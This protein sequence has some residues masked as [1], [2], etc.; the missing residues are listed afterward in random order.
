LSLK[1]INL[2]FTDLDSTVLDEN[3]NFK[4]EALDCIQKALR[5][6]FVIIF[7]SSKTLAEQQY[8]STKIGLPVIYIVENGSAI[9]I[10]EN[11]FD[12]ISH[13][14]GCRKFVLSRFSVSYVREV[15][16][17]I[18]SESQSIKF[19]GNSTLKEIMEYTGLSMKMAR[20]AKDREYTETIFKGFTSVIENKLIQYGLFPQKGSRFVTVGDKVD[21]GTA[22]TKLISLLKNEGYTIKRTIGVGDGPNDIALLKVVNEPYIIGKKIYMENIP[23]IHSL[24]QIK[25]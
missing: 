11:V 25:I 4:K 23:S 19:Y 14:K 12:N 21:K 16:S 15:L 1:E 20:L 6:K 13:E 2:F 17:Y 7:A 24:T 8:F 10:P 9:C 3:Y 18:K 22:A 5:K